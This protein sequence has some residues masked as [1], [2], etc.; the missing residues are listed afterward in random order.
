MPPLTPLLAARSSDDDFM[1]IVFGVGAVIVWGL[2]QLLGALAKKAEEAKRR[3]QYGGLPED[4]TTYGYGGRP[5]APPSGLPPYGG[6]TTTT[7]PPPP[8]PVQVP[9]GYGTPRPHQHQPKRKGN[10][11]RSK[12]AKRAAAPSAQAAERNV[13][14]ARQAFDV[15]TSSPAPLAESQPSPRRIRSG[16]PA[17]QIARLL[18]RPDSLR[19]AFIL[20]EVLSKPTALRDDPRV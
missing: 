11:G 7:P 8:V 20:N 16:V 12:A 2:F 9:P 19:A 1:K 14:V 4:V 15:A 5:T 6:R 10:A 13:A 18:R 3:E 17:G